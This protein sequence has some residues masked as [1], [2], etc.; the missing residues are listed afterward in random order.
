MYHK[1]LKRTFDLVVALGM[2]V[3]MLPIVVVVALAI[4][5]ESKGPA[6]FT[7][8]RTG[9]NGKNFKLRKFRSMTTDNDV[10]DLSRG[11]QITKVGKF[12]RSTS[13]DEIPQFINVL[14]GDMSF[15]GPRPWIPEYYQNMNQEQRQRA[16]VRPGITGLAQARGRNAITINAK[17]NY[18]L[19]YVRRISLKEDITII[20]LTVY[21]LFEKEENTIDKYGIENE[22]SILRNQDSGMIGQGGAS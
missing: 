7:Q 16:N 13:I 22:L 20:L 4:K 21:S 8:E 18:D 6:L 2:L 5:I 1:F 3:L 19:E 10:R 15:I 12:L 14:I 17:I 9:L 11:N